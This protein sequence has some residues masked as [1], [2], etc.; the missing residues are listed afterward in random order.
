MKF[1]IKTREL[2]L[3]KAL[4]EAF[5]RLCLMGLRVCQVVFSIPIIGFAAAFTSA[6]S[7]EDQN[8]P[9]KLSA[10]LAI[11]SV[12]TLYTG[13]TFLPVIFEGP[14]FFTI[15][16]IFD[17]LFVAAWS[18]LIGIWDNDGTGTCNAFINKYFD[19]RPRKSYFS[20]DC[21]LVKAMFAFMVINLI[22]LAP[23]RARA[24]YE[25]EDASDI[26]Q[27]RRKRTSLRLL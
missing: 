9:S 1:K 4:D 26:Q 12:C 17:A 7:N 13:L 5:L 10:A 23:D 20:T 18:S 25:L 19:A 6:L 11:A 24:Y 27:T 14:L 22:L 21:S 8:V 3:T 16:A 15:V 2:E